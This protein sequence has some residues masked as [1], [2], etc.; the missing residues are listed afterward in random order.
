MSPNARSPLAIS[1]CAAVAAFALAPVATASIVVAATA[2]NSNNATS[3]GTAVQFIVGA[4]TSYA[5]IATQVT[6]GTLGVPPGNTWAGTTAWIKGG[7]NSSGS[8]ATVSMSWRTATS[9]ERFGT[10]TVPPMPDSP[11]YNSLSSDV[12]NLTGITATGSVDGQGRL[13]TDAYALEMTFDPNNMVQS[14]QW[15]GSLGWDLQDIYDSGEALISYFN[16]VTGMWSKTMNVIAPGASKVENFFGDFDAFMVAESLT[17][18]S[19]LSSYVGSYG[20][21]ATTLS[22]A[23]GT[24]GPGTYVMW[25]VFDHTSTFGAVP[26]PGALGLLGTAGLIGATRRRRA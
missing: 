14:Y 17:T 18:S 19:D 11:G 3:F 2:D 10:S 6:G 24:Y 13:P 20:F 16:P 22:G 8:S 5:G 26:A 7:V 12:L 9:A 4:G 1:T 25:G 15:G 21:Y 23:A